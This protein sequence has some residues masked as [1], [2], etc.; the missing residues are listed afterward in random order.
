VIPL[1]LIFLLLP[2]PASSCLPAQLHEVVKEFAVSEHVKVTGGAY[3]GET[4]YG[5]C[6]EVSVNILCV[7]EHRH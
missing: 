1:L 2:P 4:S 5:E 6:E 3:A 7:L